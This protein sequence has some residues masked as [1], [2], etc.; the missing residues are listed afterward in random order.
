MP[1]NNNKV[2]NIINIKELEVEASKIVPKS[3]FEYVNGGAG[4]EWTFRKN[5]ESFE[6]KQIIPRVLQNIENPDLSTSILGIKIKSPIIMAPAAAHGLVHESAEKGTAKGVAESNTIM[7]V[8]TYSSD[9][10]DDIAVAGNGSLQ[11]FQLYMSKDDEFNKYMVKDAEN[12]GAKAIIITA[13]A[14]V[15]GNREA[16]IRTIL[17]FH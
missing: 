7:S 5:I 11:W 1:P 2:L 12:N 14:T 16:D 3:G 9:T 15:G 13:D 17:D 6:K 4:D 8:S 10:I